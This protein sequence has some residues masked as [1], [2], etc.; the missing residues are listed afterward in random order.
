[1]IRATG[2]RAD[3]TLQLLLQLL[4][5]DL[6]RAGQVTAF[7]MQQIELQGAQRQLRRAGARKPPQGALHAKPVGAPARGGL[8]N[9]AQ[10]A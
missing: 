8:I 6:S 4:W 1:M 2:V 5:L 10:V 7:Q 3:S 9:S